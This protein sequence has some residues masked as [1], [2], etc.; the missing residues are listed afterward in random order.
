MF[1]RRYKTYRGFSRGFRHYWHK[2]NYWYADDHF[3]VLVIYVSK[4]RG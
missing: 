3:Y 1:V 4:E 2:L